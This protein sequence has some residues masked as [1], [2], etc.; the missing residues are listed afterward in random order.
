MTKTISSSQIR[1]E[2]N[3]QQ[4]KSWLNQAID[5]RSEL[6]AIEIRKYFPSFFDAP[7][8][9]FLYAGWD[10]VH[11]DNSIL[12][13]GLSTKSR[14][15]IKSLYPEFYSLN[16]HYQEI[17]SRLLELVFGLDY[18]T[19][20]TANRQIMGSRLTAINPFEFEWLQF[21]CS[22]NRRSDVN[23]PEISL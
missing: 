15:W 17:V 23:Y 19:G 21:N 2:Y 5:Q 14:I 13:I 9:E 11:K 7:Q 18:L 16:T 10:F 1:G 3:P 8:G 6:D 4:L 12:R 22:P 20:W